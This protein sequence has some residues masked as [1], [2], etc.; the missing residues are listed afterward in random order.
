MTSEKKNEYK[1][2]V[3]NDAKAVQCVNDE[4]VCVWRVTTPQIAD[5]NAH[6][7]GGQ[8]LTQESLSR[9]CF[10]YENG[11]TQTHFVMVF[12]P[13]GGL[14]WNIYYDKKTGHIDRITEAR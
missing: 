3:E 12:R 7:V 8:V 10:E 1:L 2:V 11:M 13:Y 4:G 14:D 6:C 9:G 5:W